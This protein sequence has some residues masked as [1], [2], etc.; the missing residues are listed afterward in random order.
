MG[1]KDYGLDIGCRA[2][3]VVHEAKTIK[4]TFRMRL[5]RPYVIKGGCIIAEN[6]VVRREA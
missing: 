6:G 5:E 2:D 4:E 1:I 3:I